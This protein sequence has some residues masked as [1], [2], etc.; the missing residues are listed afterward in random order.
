MSKAKVAAKKIFSI[1]D[2][3]NTM[4]FST[5]SQEVNEKEFNVDTFKGVI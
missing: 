4:S 1:I 5:N 2:E 3:P